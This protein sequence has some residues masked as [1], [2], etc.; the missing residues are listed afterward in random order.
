[1][2]LNHAF[3]RINQY[4]FRQIRFTLYYV[5]LMLYLYQIYSDFWDLM[6]YNNLRMIIKRLM[7]T[8]I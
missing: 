3:K 5:F 6:L 8:I 1:M 4:F 7:N 2:P